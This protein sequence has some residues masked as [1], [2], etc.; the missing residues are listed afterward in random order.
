MA[1]PYYITQGRRGLRSNKGSPK[2]WF[3]IFTCS[4]Y[5]CIHVEMVP[6]ESADSFMMSFSRFLARKPRPKYINSDNGGNFTCTAK[7]VSELFENLRKRNAELANKYPD[8]HWDFNTPR[9]PH[10]GG[11]FER[12]IGSMKKALAVTLPSAGPLKEEE[13]L[14]CLITCEGLLNSRPLSYVGSNPE[15]LTPLTPSHFLLQKGYTDIAPAKG[16]RFKG[17]NFCERWLNL[18]KV[19]D[20]LW[21]RFIREVIPN[22]HR[23][24]AWVTK[25]RDLQVGDIVVLLEDKDRGVWPLGRIKETYTSSKDGRTR[26]AVVSCH[27]KDYDRSLSRLMVVQES[28]T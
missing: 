15:D 3:I 13:L 24:N 23:M 7:I 10:Q 14:T 28:S 16:Y 27:G 22:M 17:E 5:R 8:I 12:L 19:L 26:R 18:Q 2:R 9:S 25:R 6:S 4:V 20:R 1:G 21:A 11:H